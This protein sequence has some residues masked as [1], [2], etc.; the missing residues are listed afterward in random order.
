MSMPINIERMCAI[1]GKMSE[2]MVLA[3]TNRFGPP[4]L[5]LRPP[6]MERST[7]EWWIQECP[8]CCYVAKDI[9]DETSITKEWLKNREYFSCGNQQFKS[10]LAQKFYKQYMIAIKDEKNSDPYTVRYYDKY[11]D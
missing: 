3:S 5:D 11:S 4:D 1:C 2:Q 10:K 7:M 9:S 8:Y 6:E